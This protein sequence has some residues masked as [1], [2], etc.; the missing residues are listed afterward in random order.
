MDT[1][2]SPLFDLLPDAVV[3]VDSM[4]TLRDANATA[5]RQFGWTLEE[6]QGRSLLELI[7]PDDL[8]W[9]LA[10]LTTV[11]DKD[12]GTAIELRVK[13]RDGWRLVEVIG[14]PYDHDGEQR[15]VLSARDLT[16]RRMW[17]VA[18]D[19]TELFR[20]LMQNGASITLL[21]NATG[22]VTAA[23]GALTRMTGR[24]VEQVMER[25]LS[26]AVVPGDRAALEQAFELLRNGDQH[27]V[28]IEVVLSASGRAPV[29]CQFTIVDLTDDPTVGGF[30]ITGHDISELRRTRQEL[31][32]LAGHDGLTGL[33]NRSRLVQELSHRLAVG[34]QRAS[35]LVAFIDLDRF[36]PV[37]DLY[38]HDAGDEL[39]VMVAERLCNAVRREDLVARFG[40]D[41]F[42]VL[43][44]IDGHAGPRA[45]AERLHAA[46]AP[47]FELSIGTVQIAASVGVVGCD[48]GADV[49]TVLAEADAA[50]YAEKHNRGSTGHDRTVVARR[51]LAE[52]LSTALDGGE[53]VVHYQ[54]IVNLA[55]GVWVGLEALARWEHP[56]RGLLRPD[57]F[58]EVIEQTGQTARLGEVVLSRIAGDMQ[59]LRTVTGATPGI[60]INASAAEI[61][62]PSY[63]SLIAETL[64]S[65][66]ID[67]T[68]LTVEISEREM[69]ERSNR[70]RSTIPTS[71][72]A[73][74][75]AGIHL[76]VDDFGTGYS[77]LTHL[78]TFPIDQ[79]KIDRSF[80]AGVVHDP[81]RRSVIAALVGLARNTGMDVVAEGIDQ[82]QQIPILRELGCELAQGFHFARPMSY[83]AIELSYLTEVE[84]RQSVGL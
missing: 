30:V 43:A 60:A 67:P 28:T 2:A 73:L 80:V 1:A 62:S 55:T 82:T 78:V 61:T 81:Q 6:W 44:D 58:I 11:V 20:A 57:E 47:N 75:D 19:D 9:A 10:S 37:N 32:H 48:P 17:E 27:Q 53:F 59:K 68:R 52:R 84:L 16:D 42:V 25:P 31:E 4:G 69:L 29:P 72:A 24:G 79:I 13:A 15:I 40:G 7:H 23:S 49:D 46:L 41:E 71:L 51:E 33:A 21:T 45:L 54:P 63:P 74:A 77:S 5:S 14:T 22:I 12:V 18:G 83:E 35:T 34:D 65:S 66:G 56:E 36:K 64:R 39:L 38:G 8:E 26:E 70:S 3:V 76:A 50:M